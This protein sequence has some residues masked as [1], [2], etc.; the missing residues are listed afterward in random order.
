M[1]WLNSTALCQHYKAMR[2]TTFRI[3]LNEDDI[4][5]VLPQYTAIKTTSVCRH[6]STMSHFLCQCID[7]MFIGQKCAVTLICDT[8]R[9]CRHSSRE[10]AETQTD[11]LNTGPTGI[12]GEAGD[13]SRA[14]VQSGPPAKSLSST[15]IH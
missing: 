2:K 14:M 6:Y 4:S 9:L 10:R 3:A 13:K 11:G 7:N 15:P 12:G 8:T 1:V 5:T